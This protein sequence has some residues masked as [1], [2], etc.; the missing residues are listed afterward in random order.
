ML[1]AGAILRCCAVLPHTVARN[2]RKRAGCT[3][4]PERHGGCRSL[5]SL[6]PPRGCVEIF[7]QIHLSARRPSREMS[8]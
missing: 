5:A 1:I 6:L 8:L 3:F 7:T 2:R 4:E